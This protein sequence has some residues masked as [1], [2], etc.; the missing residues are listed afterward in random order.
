MGG[1]LWITVFDKKKL[2]NGNIRKTYIPTVTGV[3]HFFA[4][5][6][7]VTNDLKSQFKKWLRRW[8]LPSEQH[9]PPFPTGL[10]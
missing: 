5:K 9:S 6:Y 2:R 4:P 1:V 10:P 7:E 3:V 8:S